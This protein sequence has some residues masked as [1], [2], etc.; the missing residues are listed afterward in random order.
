MGLCEV[1]RLKNENK[2]LNKKINHYKEKEINYNKKIEELEQNNKSLSDYCSDL[3]RTYTDK[4][5]FLEK[6]LYMAQ[7]QQMCNNKNNNPKKINLIFN[8]NDI[9]KYPIIV[10][11]NQ[12][13]F[14]IFQ[15]ICLA[16]NINVNLNKTRFKYNTQDITQYFFNNK[17]VSSLNLIL[18]FPIIDVIF[19]NF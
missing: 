18:D 7:C 15:N 16:H 6:Q 9:K 11:P 17:E 5:S 10:S 3:Q 4:I 14:D 19:S 1:K 13:L 2:L 12:K 8:I